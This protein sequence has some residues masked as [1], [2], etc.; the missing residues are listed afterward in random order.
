MTIG[1]KSQ[2][3]LLALA[4]CLRL[5]AARGAEPGPEAEARFLS[6]TRQLILE[7]RRSGE[8]YFSPDGKALIFQSEREPGNPFY[9]IYT[10]DLE[11]GDIARVSPGTGK[12][13]CAF[14]RPGSDEVLF[15]ST[16]LDP[17]A[18][19]K[20]KAEFDLRASGKQRRYSWDYDE[21]M[22]IFIAR[23]DGSNLRQLTRTPGYDAEA[24]FSPDGQLVVFSSLREAYPTNKLSAADLKRLETDPSWFADIYLMNADGS[25][26]RRLTDTPGYDGG[27][28]FSPDSRRIVWRRFN[29]SGDRADVYTMNVDGS[30][31][32]R[33]TDFGAMSW[34]PY[35]HPSGRYIIFTANKLGFGNFELFLVDAEGT[36]EP[37]R[38]TY[39]DGFD[40]LPV[41]SP[42]GA[43]LAWTSG[44]TPDGKSQIFIANWNHAAAL[45]DLKNAAPRQAHSAT[46]VVAVGSASP[47]PDPATTAGAAGIVSASKRQ[48]NFSG[49]ISTNDLQTIVAHLASP[50]LE[51]RLAGSRGAGL[52][53]DYIE[54][55]MKRI[56]LQA[57]GTNDGFF[58]RYE[59]NA[60]A[61][62]LTNANHMVV[63]P[64]GGASVDFAVEQDFRPLEF[65]ANA[66]VEGEVVF[67]GYGLTV[68]GTSGEGYDSYG[69]ADVSNRIALVLRYAPEQVETKRRAE[70]N[71]YAAL[72]YKAMHARE[73]GAKAVVFVTGPGSPNA[74]ELIRMSSDSSLSGSAIPVASVSNNVAAALLANSGKT[75]G[76]LQAAL[77]TEN[78]H[79][80]STLVLTNVRLRLVTAV[81]HVRKIDRNVLGLLPSGSSAS[82]S[83]P[84]E[85]LLIGAHYDHLG[86]GET[87]AMNRKGE[88][89]LIHPG[90]D[91]NASGVATML[92]LAATLA[93]E[94]ARSPDAFPRGMIFAAWAGEEIGTI[95]SSWFADHPL[96]P[97][98]NITAYL[99]FDM[100]GR[101]RDNKLT[102]QGIGSSPDWTKLIE[103][104]NV[105]AGFNLTLQEDP[106][107]PTDT[108]PLYPRGVPVLAF[109]TGGHDDYHRPTDQPDTLN[110]EGTARIARLARGILADLEKAARPTYAQITNTAAG[111]ARENLRAYVGTIPDYAAEVQG[112]KLSGVRAGGPADRAGI[113]GG[114]VVVEFA[115]SKIANIYDYTYALDAVKI[116]QPVSLVVLRDGQRVI[117]T[118]TPEAR[119]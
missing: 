87:G 26:V 73:H 40:G 36:R 108:T 3:C 79:A 1:N 106:Y 113:K 59:F 20:Q 77:D 8:G 62:V 100:V 61:R 64:T 18:T 68:P 63:T 85:Y 94:R 65:T 46:N 22:D 116:G 27:P 38:V 115:G 55:Q 57:V 42:N 71:R 53:A 74:G 51:G 10:L 43:K 21:R 93:A 119:K 103:K 104:R 32:R 69:G 80:L 41:F 91:D 45:D 88:E 37:V 12:T 84:A 49:D 90:A 70:L 25:N 112:V 4:L 72:R 83:R 67:V 15:A 33:L 101:L 105:A 44:R 54:A 75:L 24:S 50:E 39:T 89:G 28:F 78:P 23:R 86:F 47:Q 98:T 66:E 2:C 117:L 13:T 99:N 96:L 34:A 48:P 107:L 11:S 29:E 111:G 52:A 14:F 58:Q 5:A 19:A 9:Q 30:D 82:V 95:G 110:Y 114:D 76:E 6:G 16:H 7:G 56:G 31:V 92:E 97:L 118:V 35:F 102:L 81:E 60:G 109:F 17:E